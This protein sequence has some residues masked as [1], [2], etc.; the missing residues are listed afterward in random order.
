[1]SKDCQRF[2]RRLLEPK[3]QKRI[4]AENALREKWIQK[5][6]KKLKLPSA[7]LPKHI[8]TRLASYHD[9]GHLQKLVRVIIAHAG[10]REQMIEY[11]NI[12]FSID[13]DHSGRIDKEELIEVLQQNGLTANA[14]KRLFKSIDFDD[15]GSIRF[16]E[17]V[18][19]VMGDSFTNEQL[20]DVFNRVRAHCGCITPETL[21]KVCE[22]SSIEE[23][24]WILREA[25]ADIEIAH[26]ASGSK[27]MSTTGAQCYANSVFAELSS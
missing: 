27:R 11:Q 23:C 25:R 6:A 16:S 1:M 3:P 8:L 26:Q 18:A 22:D 14:A 5:Y 21:Q 12:F 9:T 13:Y 19:A 2:I 15:S 4:S 24:R 10:C 20:R 17:F 7:K